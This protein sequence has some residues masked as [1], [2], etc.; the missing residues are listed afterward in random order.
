MIP[1]TNFRIVQNSAICKNCKEE[2]FSR[3]VHDFRS[4]RCGSVAV[5]GGLDYPRRIFRDKNYYIETSK[6]E[7]VP[8]EEI[9][10]RLKKHALENSTC[11]RRQIACALYNH[12]GYLAASGVNGPLYPIPDCLR[13][14]NKCSGALVEPGLS[15]PGCQGFHAELSAII[16]ALKQA[17]NLNGGIAYCTKAPCSTCVNALVFAG[18]SKVYFSLDSN[19]QSNRELWSA[20]HEG[21]LSNWIHV[22]CES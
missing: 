8:P 6:Y 14:P 9:L 17:R 20:L 15:A 19:D 12:E 11:S 7:E 3:S 18:I 10:F 13:S 4:C 22:P 21:D 2:I 5:D 16:T 1:Q